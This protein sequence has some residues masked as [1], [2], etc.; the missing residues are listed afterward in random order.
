[1]KKKILRKF[2]PFTVAI[3]IFLVLVSVSLLY[4]LFWSLTAAFKTQEEFRLNK[5]GLPENWT[6]YN[7]KLVYNN[8]FVS[9]TVDGYPMKVYVPQLTI[10]TIMYVFGCSF[11]GTL[12][13][14]IVA[15]AVTKV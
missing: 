4:L 6:F 9:I 3:F 14:C 10:N 5:L 2:D 12:T 8:L 7:F 11:M 15:Y 1:M 13:P